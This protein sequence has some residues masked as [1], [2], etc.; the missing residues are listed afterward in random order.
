MLE[1]LHNPR[2]QRGRSQGVVSLT[3]LKPRLSARPP[4]SFLGL[5]AKS[6]PEGIEKILQDFCQPSGELQLP[7]TIEQLVKI[8][9]PGS[10]AVVTKLLDDLAI[11]PSGDSHASWDIAIGEAIDQLEELKKDQS[12]DCEDVEMDTGTHAQSPEKDVDMGMQDTG[13]HGRTPENI[14][15][16]PRL[17][18]ISDYMSQSSHLLS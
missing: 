11:D 5:L 18:A 9:G 12:E 6:L 8:F 17:K 2:I 7:D 3:I 10:E 16:Q 14:A 15:Q 1:R 13:T 4:S